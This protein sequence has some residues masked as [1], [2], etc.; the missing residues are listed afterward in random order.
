MSSVKVL[1]AISTQNP[2]HGMFDNEIIKAVVGCL[3]NNHVKNTFMFRFYSFGLTFALFFVW[4]FLIVQQLEFDDPSY[5]FWR[6]LKNGDLFRDQF[7]SVPKGEQNMT[8]LSAT[9]LL[10][11]ILWIQVALHIPRESMQFWKTGPSAYFSEKGNLNDILCVAMMGYLPYLH[12]AASL[13]GDDVA[14]QQSHFRQMLVV[15]ALLSMTIILKL[16]TYMQAL[17]SFGFMVNMFQQ[18]MVDIYY[19]VIL[20]LLFQIAFSNAFFLLFAQTLTTGSDD[21]GDDSVDSVDDATSATDDAGGDDRDDTFPDYDYGYQFLSTYLMMLGEFDL[22]EFWSLRN[23]WLVILLF[24]LWLFG[25]IIVLLNVLIAVLSD[26]YQN[27]RGI[28]DAANL[29]MRLEIIVEFLEE[30]SERKLGVIM[31]ETRWVHALVPV[32]AKERA[33]QEADD[34]DG[35]DEEDKAELIH[36]ADKDKE[37]L[38]V[39]I[40]QM[41]RAVDDRMNNGHLEQVSKL[42]EMLGRMKKDHSREMQKTI[43]NFFFGN[44]NSR[45]DPDGAPENDSSGNKMMKGALDGKRVPEIAETEGSVAGAAGVTAGESA[46]DDA[47]PRT[48]EVLGNGEV[49]PDSIMGML[50]R[51]QSNWDAVGGAPQ[52]PISAQA[53]DLAKLE[54]NLMQRLD[55]HDARHDARYQ[56][57]QEDVRGLHERFNA[58][59]DRMEVLGSQ[60][61]S[62]TEVIGRVA[63][64]VNALDS[65][66]PAQICN[67]VDSRLLS[68]EF[69]ERF[70][71]ASH[72]ARKKFKRAA[73]A[74]Q[75]AVHTAQADMERSGDRSVDLG[76]QPSRQAS[77]A[78]PIVPP[79]GGARTSLRQP[80]S[81]AQIRSVGGDRPLE[82]SDLVDPGVAASDRY[83]STPE[84]RANQR[85]I[86]DYGQRQPSQHRL[87]S[88]ADPALMHAEEDGGAQFERQPSQHRLS[89]HADPAPMHAEQDGGARFDALVGE[90][91]RLCDE[92]AS[93]P[94]QE[95]GALISRA[96]ALY[97]TVLQSSSSHPVANVGRGF[98]L[99]RLG[100]NDE[101]LVA[102]D[103]AIASD[104]DGRGGLELRRAWSL[105]SE[106]LQLLG[107]VD[108][109]HAAFE[110]ALSY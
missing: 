4:S 35:F 77:G 19:F 101:A 76:S 97:E 54:G 69:L 86:R 84:Q 100:R 1:D 106:T 9:F 13:E 109:A 73:T 24:I 83:S 48:E 105:K 59:E 88:H 21:A 6:G 33:A 44:P 94:R 28:S 32:S 38:L 74:V 20:L 104:P 55:G 52:S 7:S 42:D 51:S 80:V 16:L 91:G 37:E 65:R 68:D 25:S 57:T 53:P 108:E 70:V 87:S 107:R 85:Q 17:E 29:K 89:S 96:L 12:V 30:S 40:N 18:I 66:L 78:E 8:I 98:C 46:A 27:V 67:A 103:A 50:R 61:I 36:E 75:A 110:R 41:F 60:L 95:R 31:E 79:Q 49:D 11:I 64:N 5:N 22:A 92:S 45:D 58:F 63:E 102:L 39:T 10:D 56:A 3:W 62:I 23:R 81:D 99:L 26:S 93:A 47:S 15:G 71:E 82:P 2:K 34:H 90:A 43:G 72:S 14:K